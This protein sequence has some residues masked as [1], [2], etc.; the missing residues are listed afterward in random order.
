M[1][2]K[3][4]ITQQQHANEKGWHNID[5]LKCQ[6]Q[7]QQLQ[8]KIAVAYNTGRKGEYKQLQH[9]LT[10]SFAA[11]A[12]AVRTVVTNPGK[13]NP[14]VDK[15][16]WESPKEKWDNLIQLGNLSHYRA[17]P[18]RRVWISKD[19]KQV[20]PDK[21]NGRPLGIPTMFDRAIQSVWNL[22]LS[23]IAECTGDRHSYGF[24]PYRSSQ[25]AKQMLYIRLA[26][27]YRPE[28]ILQADIKGLF[29]NISHKWIMANIP[30]NAFLLQQWLKAGQIE[31]EETGAGVPQGG[32]I[33]PTISNM[34]LD[35]LSDK[36]QKAVAPYTN[37]KGRVLPNTKCTMIRYADDFI[38]TCADKELIVNVIQP[39]IRE[40]LGC[41][42]LELSEKK[43]VITHIE[44]GFDFLGWNCQLYINKLLIKPSKKSIDRIK[45]RIKTLFDK[46]SKSSAYTLI[47]QL[48]PVI[49]G[50]ANYHRTAVSKVCFNKIGHYLW[51]KVWK[52]IRAKHTRRGR[53]ELVK[54]YF[55]RIGGRNW[56]FSGSKGENKLTLFDIANVPIV[57]HTLC[58]DYN[59][60]LPEHRDY[61]NKRRK[62][63]TI[64]NG[65]WDKR[66]TQLLK[67]EGYQCPLCEMPVLYGQEL[68]THHKLARKL[69]GG[70]N[71]GNLVILHKECHKQ[72]TYCSD[73][74]LQARF[75]ERGIVLTTIIPL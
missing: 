11:R 1:N 20:L 59:C 75:V 46:H 17:S 32:P 39:A 13:K 53:R 58:R 7:V 48:N 34:V 64:A 28:W 62:D 69:G 49:H 61:F 15:C 67:R 30:V 21:S 16:V 51:T 23:P 55:S 57:R 66:S 70:E 72:C 14:G 65:L 19:G 29:N 45:E 3:K 47:H 56:A 60:Y 41:R 50:W 9:N 25:D 33:S 43:T 38:V 36:I 10:K 24:R 37:K 27:R 22:A 2:S 42:G 35:G 8:H 31:L 54:M 4:N 26:N 74:V 63:G 73:P 18:I 5:W 6:N 52:W 40:F 44:D 71:R 12:L 68:E